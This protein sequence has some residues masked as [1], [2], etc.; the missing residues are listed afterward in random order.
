MDEEKE[1]CDW[2]KLFEFRVRA[3]ERNWK[4]TVEPEGPPM[5]SF[6]VYWLPRKKRFQVMPYGVKIHASLGR[7]ATNPK[8]CSCGYRKVRLANQ[9]KC[10][11]RDSNSQ[12]SA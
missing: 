10:P 7:L 4:V 3:K 9:S 1:L 12:F 11:R 6:K 8:T 5:N 2:C